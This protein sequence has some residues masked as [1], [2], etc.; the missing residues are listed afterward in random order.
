[1]AIESDYFPY[2]EITAALFQAALFQAALFHAIRL[3]N[4]APNILEIKALLRRIAIY[5]SIKTFNR[6]M[7]LD[8][9]EHRKGLQYNDPS[10]F[11]NAKEPPF[12]MAIKNT[13]LKD[14]SIFSII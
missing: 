7:S 3:I 4:V 13:T 14:Y 9:C 6:V 2:L 8:E 1:M 5:F 11:K 12:N 10:T